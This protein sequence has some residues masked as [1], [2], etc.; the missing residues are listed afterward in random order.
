MDD[1]K[2]Y[3]MTFILPCSETN[4]CSLCLYL[5]LANYI[6]KEA[7][8]FYYKLWCNA[9]LKPQ[10]GM[11]LIFSHGHHF[12]KVVLIIG[13]AQAMGLDLIWLFMKVRCWFI[14]FDGSK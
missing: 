5:V 7:M 1:R 9:L 3:L 14:L 6:S 4:E 10:Q 13:T 2:L 11:L 8:K 12:G